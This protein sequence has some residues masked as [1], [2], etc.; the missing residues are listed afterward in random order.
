MQALTVPFVFAIINLHLFEL[1]I[2]MA[3]IDFGPSEVLVRCR[4]IEVATI[5]SFFSFSSFSL[6]GL[7]FCK[8]SNRNIRIPL[9]K[10]LG[11]PLPTE[12]CSIVYAIYGR[13]KREIFKSFPTVPKLGLWRLRVRKDFWKTST[14]VDAQTGASRIC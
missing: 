9:K 5:N 7:L 2:Q 14:H 12:L 13:T 8:K 3:C 11:S 10:K 6:V 1:E 4:Q